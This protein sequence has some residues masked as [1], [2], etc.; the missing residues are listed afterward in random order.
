VMSDLNCN[1]YIGAEGNQRFCLHSNSVRFAMNEIID[2]VT[3]DVKGKGIKLSLC[4][5][6]YHAMKTYWG[7]EV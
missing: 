2:A 3:S 1:T 5:T 7:V 6:K 4:L